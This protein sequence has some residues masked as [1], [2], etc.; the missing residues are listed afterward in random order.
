ML[1]VVFDVTGLPTVLAA[2]SQM[3]RRMGTVVLV[4]DTTMPSRQF[5]GPNVLSDSLSIL[6]SHGSLCPSVATEFNPWTWKEMASLFFELLAA[7]K[8]D[9]RSLTTAVVPPRDAP[10]VYGDLR[11]E[12]SAQIGVVFDWRKV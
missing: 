1:D 9:V 5:L 7:N 12:P 10:K 6:G 4:G 8:L 11:E 3:V 2:A